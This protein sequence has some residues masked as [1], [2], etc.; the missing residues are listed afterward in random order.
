MK[1]RSVRHVRVNAD[2]DYVRVGTCSRCRKIDVSIVVHHPPS[3]DRPF[4]VC[5][6]CS[7]DLWDSVG[8]SNKENFLKWGSVTKQRK[9]DHT[10]RDNKN[11]KRNGTRDNNSSNGSFNRDR[12]INKDK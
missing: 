8:E 5:N 11:W 4:S 12:N 9:R 2:R 3:G 10:N 7:K 6:Y 1:M